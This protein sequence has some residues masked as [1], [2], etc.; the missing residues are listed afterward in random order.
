MSAQMDQYVLSTDLK[1]RLV[2]QL[3]QLVHSPDGQRISLQNWNTA[4]LTTLFSVLLPADSPETIHA[5]LLDFSRTLVPRI[6]ALWEAR[7]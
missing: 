4:Q 3:I 7:K 5:V 6:D 2:P 1:R